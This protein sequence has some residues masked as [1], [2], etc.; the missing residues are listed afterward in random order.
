MAFSCGRNDEGQL[1]AGND[2]IG[3]SKDETQ[4]KVDLDET[5]LRIGSG[6]SSQSVFFI[7][8]DGVWAAGLNDRYQ[9]GTGEVGSAD[10]PVPVKFEGP[11]QIEFVSSSGTHTV[12]NGRYV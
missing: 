1:G 12:A 6:P 7:G 2:F 3:S 4:F 10:K 9:L 8:A 5:I 11:V